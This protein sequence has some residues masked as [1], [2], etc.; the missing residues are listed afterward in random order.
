ML[1][2]AGGSKKCVKR[3]SLGAAIENGGC[4]FYAS[5]RLNDVNLILKK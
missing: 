2:S 4:E 3:G 5:I 1:L